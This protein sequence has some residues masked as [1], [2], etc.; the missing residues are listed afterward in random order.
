MIGRIG[1][2]TA[3]LLG[4]VLLACS[5]SIAAEESKR[6]PEALAKAEKATKD[7]LATLKGAAARVDYIK[8]DAVESAFPKAYF[9]AV[10][11]PQFP[12]G[13]VPPKDL[14][15]SNLFA[16]DGDGKVT[17]LTE[18]AGLEK[19]F[20]AN[21]TAKG[22]AAKKTA[23]QAWLRLSQQYHQDGFYA[24]SLM[25]DALKVDGKK[26]SGVVVVM[27]GGSG[28]LSAA[29]TFD[30]DGKLDKVSEEAKL[31]RGPRPIC[32]ATKLLDNDPLVRRIAEEDLVIMGPAAKD[33]LDE[34]RVKAEPE[35]QR[36][37]DRVWQRIQ[38]SER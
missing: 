13:R 27:R 9:F 12:V 20:Q 21:N 35:L 19:F 38:A 32:Q 23:V 29:L 11:F 31:R 6:T 36:A 2:G 26:A 33:Y 14:K 1:S 25:E 4:V 18:R 15:V 30:D 24:F 7:H 16:V 34:Q 5:W 3:L 10:F 28:T 22:D 37:I 8:D 17:V